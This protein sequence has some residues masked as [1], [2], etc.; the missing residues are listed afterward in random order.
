MKCLFLDRDGVVNVDNHYVS[1]LSDFTFNK[2]IFNLVSLF[3]NK[4]YKIFIVTNQSGINRKLISNLQL[5]TIHA[6]MIS[7]FKL[8]GIVIEKVFV[9]P[10]TPNENCSCRKP[11]IGMV[12]QLFLE[13]N[14]D[15]EN[16]FMFGDKNSDMEFANNLNLKNKVFIGSN[17]ELADFSFKNITESYNFFL[18][19]NSF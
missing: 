5:Q 17:N 6:Y 1:K 12:E 9:C 7:M 14:I 3:H 19:N 8:N 2:N 16:S 11:N 15:L 13:N 4:G 10:H 18:K